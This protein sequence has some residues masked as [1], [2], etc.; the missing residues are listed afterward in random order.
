MN[1]KTNFTEPV[2]IGGAG[3]SGTRVV[4]EILIQLGFY[5]GSDLNSANDNLWFTLLFKRPKWFIK[6]SHEKESEIFKGLSIFEK[7]M[8]GRLI[9]K[10]G[11]FNLIMRAAV[12][13]AITGHD[14]L[15]SGR[16]IW[17]FVRALTI[18]KSGKHDTSG[19]TSWGWKEPNTHIYI[20]FLSKHFDNLKYIHVIRHGL[21]M[22]FSSNQ[23]QLYNW[24]KLFGI[25]ANDSSMS[26]PKASLKYWIELNKRA[27]TLGKTL[28]DKRFLIVNF[29][30]LC[31]NPKH[32]M[33]SILDFL[34][35]NTKCLNSYQLKL[36]PKL[37]KSAGRYKNHS[38]SIFSEDEIEAVKELGFVIDG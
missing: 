1:N 20:E 12:K 6:K 19:Y 2:A 32:E 14:H 38:L 22:A 4:A 17:P 26:L 11:E 5:M 37:P 16:G 23:A 35:V 9:P 33:D 8:T 25:Q 18:L 27:I 30:E 21:D 7:A 34:G 13:M 24:G 10:I 28:L 3:G 29:D 36:L 15:H 31:L